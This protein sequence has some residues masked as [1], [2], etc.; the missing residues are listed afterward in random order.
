MDWYSARKSLKKVADY[1]DEQR[2]LSTKR[3]ASTRE[4]MSE[5]G[6]D[7][8]RIIQGLQEMLNID[9]LGDSNDEFEANVINDRIA[10][11]ELRQRK[12]DELLG[13]KHTSDDSTSQR[14]EQSTHDFVKI[15]KENLEGIVRNYNRIL[16]RLAK[17]D[18][19]VDVANQCASV[20]WRWYEARFIKKYTHVPKFKYDIFRIKEVMY[21]L[22]VMFGYYHSQGKL[23]VFLDTFNTWVKDLSVNP[24]SNK[25]IAPW[26][27]YQL[28][29]KMD[30]AFTNL[31]A[32]VIWDILLE[33]GLQDLCD[34][35]PNNEVYPRDNQI[36]EIMSKH[37]IKVLDPYANYKEDPS[38]LLRLRLLQ[39]G[40]SV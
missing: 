30:P 33:N 26:E 24:Q 21:A 9:L 12:H 16:E 3:Y 27:V 23:D 31:D 1:I 29:R 18:C 37:N 38:I 35:V 13:L 14:P 22:V 25:W 34:A 8:I 4:L 17:V 2:R 7:G 40:G 15:P 20:I 19:Q 5:M 36:W 10:A 11:L 28:E 32:V 39:E 6:E